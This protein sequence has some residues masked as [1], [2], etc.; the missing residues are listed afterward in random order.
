MANSLDRR[1]FLERT[2]GVAAGIVSLVATR[3]LAG[4]EAAPP[5]AATQPNVAGIG[6]QLY[7]EIGR[8]S[9]R[10]RVSPRV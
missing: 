5:L 9:C 4:E 3:S 8:A 10:E 6:L 7:T 1:G 2:A